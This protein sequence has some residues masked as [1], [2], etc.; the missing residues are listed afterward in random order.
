M[1]DVIVRPAGPL[2]HGTDQH[3]AIRIVAGGSGANQAAWLAR[4]GIQARLAGC[5][6]R[7]DHPA[8]V[9]RMRLHAIEPVLAAHPLLPTGTLV[10]MVD[11]SGERSFLT[12]R[13]ANDGLLRSDLPEGVLD[14][15][16]HLHVS[17]Y[18]FVGEATRSTAQLLIHEAQQAGIPVSFDAGSAAFIDDLGPDRM[19]AWT[20]GSDLC[21][22][23]VAEAEALTGQAGLDDQLHG[24]A[25]HFAMVVVKR[26]AEGAAAQASDGTRW[27]IAAPAVQAV[28]TTGAGDV[29]FA[30]FL[31]ARLGG[32]PVAECLERAVAAGAYAVTIVGGWPT[33]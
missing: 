31:A 13:G 30:A 12:D 20:A 1:R 28:D 3:A 10:A 15:V 24:L 18:S 19:L 21:V 29:F 32:A 4:F 9:E 17:G 27:S 7:E 8:Q 23:N 14:G 16:A 26:G 5:I 22:A 2:R 6:G 11:P 25:A 33:H